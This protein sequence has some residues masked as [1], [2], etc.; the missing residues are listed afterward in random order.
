MGHYQGITLV[1]AFVRQHLLS[2]G[3]AGERPTRA[4]HSRKPKPGLP[5]VPRPKNGTSN[6]TSEKLNT[7][8]TLAHNHSHEK[9]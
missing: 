2:F 6:G 8:T 9:P 1:L 7:A 3:E 4:G 5:N